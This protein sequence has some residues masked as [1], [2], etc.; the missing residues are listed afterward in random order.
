RKYFVHGS[1]YFI[2]PIITLDGIITYDI[3]EVPVN[4]SCFVQF[5][6]DHIVR[7][8]LPYGS[9]SLNVGDLCDVRH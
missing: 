4:G 8:K 5:L 2:V 9:C 1:Q 3:I 6:K 7:I